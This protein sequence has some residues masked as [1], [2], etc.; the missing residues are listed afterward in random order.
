MVLADDLRKV[1]RRSNG[2]RSRKDKKDAGGEATF[3]TKEEEEVEDKLASLYETYIP[4]NPHSD[5][6]ESRFVALL[7]GSHGGRTDVEGTD[8]AV[9]DV[10]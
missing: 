3:I 6:G 1:D 8:R 7:A 4:F 9:A 2:R 5:G 10:M